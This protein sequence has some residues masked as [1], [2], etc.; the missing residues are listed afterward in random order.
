MPYER[1]RLDLEREGFQH[2]PA[3]ERAILHLQK[4]Y[5]QL[6]AQPEPT[7]AK[8]AGGLLSRLTGRDKPAA[9]SSN[10]V[11]RGLYMWG[12]VGRGKTYLVDTFV[13]ALPIERKQR[14]HFHSFMRAVHSELKQLKQQQEPLRIVAQRF[15]EKARVICLD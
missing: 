14:I 7:P 10:P 15:A 8:K 4:I 12:G 5:D 1:Y 2:D 9:V 6:M 3:Q 13:D 11:V